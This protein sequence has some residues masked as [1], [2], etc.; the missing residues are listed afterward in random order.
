MIMPVGG[1]AVVMTVI[2]S[3]IVTVIVRMVRRRDRCIGLGV[4]MGMVV[5]RRRGRRVDMID[6]VP[7]VRVGVIVVMAAI[8]RMIVTG[9]GDNGDGDF[10]VHVA[11]GNPEVSTESNLSL[12][13][14]PATCPRIVTACNGARFRSRFQEDVP[15]KA[16]A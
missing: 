1:V 7:R 11:I 10:P 9:G 16:L 14:G 15:M 8:M 5:R 6:A 13:L 2:V 12:R 4:I 3:V